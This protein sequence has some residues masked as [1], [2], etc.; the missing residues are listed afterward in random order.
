M[1]LF[2]CDDV[3]NMDNYIGY[4]TNGD[5]GFNLNQPVMFQSFSDEFILPKQV[6]T[7]PAIPVNK[8]KKNTEENVGTP[9]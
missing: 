9:D 6:P 1:R 4:N 2:D 8:L 3:G 5:D 7:I